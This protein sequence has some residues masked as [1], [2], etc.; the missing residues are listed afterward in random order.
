MDLLST[1]ATWTCIAVVAAAMAGG[2]LTLLADCLVRGH[3]P[4]DAE[5]G[6]AADRYLR[7]Y[8]ARALRVIGDHMLAASFSPDA[9]HH[10]FL[11]RVSAELVARAVRL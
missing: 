1:A 7:Y 2:A 10:A 6:S 11:R 5:V 4:S 8:G 3:E 9:R